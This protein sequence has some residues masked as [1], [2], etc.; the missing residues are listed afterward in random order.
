MPLASYVLFP[1]LLSQGSVNVPV[2]LVEVTQAWEATTTTVAT[3]DTA[4]LV[5]ETAA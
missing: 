4:V 3:R 5:P 1:Q 2:L